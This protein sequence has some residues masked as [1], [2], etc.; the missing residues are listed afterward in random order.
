MKTFERS[1][2]QPVLEQAVAHV[3]LGKGMHLDALDVPHGRRTVRGLLRIT[4]RIARKL[5]C[6]PC[7]FLVLAF[8]CFHAERPVSP[9][10]QA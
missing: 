9:K 1:E 8:D 6:D 4:A 7:T 5:G 10:A 2:V 3:L